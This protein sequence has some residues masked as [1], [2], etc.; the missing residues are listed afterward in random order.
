MGEAS[1]LMGVN[2]WVLF[3]RGRCLELMDCVLKLTDQ[4]QKLMDLPKN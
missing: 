2:G 1:I 4:L 3:V